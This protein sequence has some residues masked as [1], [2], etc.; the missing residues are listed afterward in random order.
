MI[1]EIRIRHKSKTFTVKV[2]LPWFV[3]PSTATVVGIDIAVS[4]FSWKH[5][6]LHVRADGD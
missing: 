2:I 1:M 3:R 5:W 4:M 6:A